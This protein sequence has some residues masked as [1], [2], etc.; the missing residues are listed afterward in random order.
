MS[1][2]GC[3]EVARVKGKNAYWNKI[4]LSEN[5]I[6]ARSSRLAWEGGWKAEKEWHEGY[7]KRGLA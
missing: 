3:T 5:P 7:K 1:D 6:R 4:P 2:R